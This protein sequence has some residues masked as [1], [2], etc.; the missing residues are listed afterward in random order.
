ME[1]DAWKEGPLTGMIDL[2]L[3]DEDPE[4]VVIQLEEED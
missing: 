3:E 1:E 2:T 4:H